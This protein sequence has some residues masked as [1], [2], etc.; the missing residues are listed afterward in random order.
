MSRLGAAVVISVLVVTACSGSSGVA[1][2][3][4]PSI[5]TTTS[6]ATTTTKAVTPTASTAPFDVQAFDLMMIDAMQGTSYLGAEVGS[7]AWEISLETFRSFAQ[8]VVCEDLAAGVPEATVRADLLESEKLD[9]PD[10][11]VD[12][13]IFVDALLDAS[14]TFVCPDF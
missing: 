9:D 13:P 2:N 8:F 7:P 4:S 1:T 14:T 11:D 12:V 3:T 10:I 5:T 6:K